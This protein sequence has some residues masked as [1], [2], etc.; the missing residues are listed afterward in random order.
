[1]SIDA[2]LLFWFNTIELTIVYLD[3]F[4]QMYECAGTAVTRSAGSAPDRLFEPRLRTKSFYSNFVSI[5]SSNPFPKMST[6]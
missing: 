2:T 4:P 6:D 3:V 1:M 5:L